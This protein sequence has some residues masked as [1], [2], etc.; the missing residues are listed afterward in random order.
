MKKIG[1]VLIIGVLFFSHLAIGLEELEESIQDDSK[2]SLLWEATIHFYESG[3]LAW[4]VTCME[5]T[6]SWGGPPNDPQDVL[7]LPWPNTLDVWFDDGLSYPYNDLQVDSRFGPDT[8]FYKQW[9]LTVEN[10]APATI[11]MIWNPNDF[12]TTEYKYVNLTDDSYN[13]LVDMKINSSYEFYYDWYLMD[14]H[15]VCEQPKADLLFSE[16]LVLYPGWNLFTIPYNITSHFIEIEFFHNNDILTW[17]EAVSQFIIDANV[18]SWNSQFQTYGL[19]SIFQ[20]GVGYWIFNYNDIIIMHFTYYI[21][22][23]DDYITSLYQGWNLIGIPF[24][25]AI[26]VSDIIVNVD[27]IDYPWPGPCI[28]PFLF[29]YNCYTGLYQ[30]NNTCFEPGKGYWVYSNCECTLWKD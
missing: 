20:S 28:Q 5:D 22:N 23:T 11:D 12:Q 24:D 9:N 19:S 2:R 8:D 3:G 14:F 30:M 26:N 6:T 1:I 18:F 16:Y 10:Y 17:S 7:N 25:T 21:E 29:G 13:F 27:G 4:H 15:I